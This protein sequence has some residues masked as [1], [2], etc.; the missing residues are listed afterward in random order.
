MRIHYLQHVPF[1]DPGF[2]LTWAKKHGWGVTHTPLYNYPKG[3]VPF[4]LIRDFDWLVI[5]G[6]PM[7]VYEEAEYPW[8]AEEKLFIKDVVD[9]GKLIIGLCLGAQLLSCVLGGKVTRN[10]CK[11]IGWFPVSLSPEASS[12]PLFS[13]LPKNPLVFQ[14]HGDTFSIPEGAVHL[15]E[16]EACKNQAFMYRDRIFAFQFHLENTREIIRGLV[17]HCGD[18]LAEEEAKSGY[19]Q[20]GAELLSHPEHIAQDNQWMDEFLTR[21]KIHYR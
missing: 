9:R 19:V 5:M 10:P 16:S 17:D 11:E 8:L 1:E 13:F 7:N 18:E 6:G 4:P 15:A 3:G 21:L 12:L 2:I 20:T 14:W